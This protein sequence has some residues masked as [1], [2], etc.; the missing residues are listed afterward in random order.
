MDQF[1]Q[2]MAAYVTQLAR[3]FWLSTDAQAAYA[4]SLSLETSSG[5]R[6][7]M[8][9]RLISFLEARFE[10]LRLEVGAHEH[11]KD[12]AKC[13]WDEAGNLALSTFC[14][15]VESL[16]QP[17]SRVTYDTIRASLDAGMT[18]E[19][20]ARA[21]RAVAPPPQPAPAPPRGLRFLPRTTGTL[22]KFGL[23]MG[24]GFIEADGRSH[25]VNWTK[26][27]GINQDRPDARVYHRMEAPMLLSFKPVQL[28]SGDW[29]AWDVTKADGSEIEVLPPPF[30]QTAEDPA[31]QEQN[32]T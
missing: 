26:V 2:H 14:S 6:V 29:Q 24:F 31:M 23:N 28:R 22:V 27:R 16:A 3:E 21:S 8:A 10:G 1:K 30:P 9:G 20:R 7:I 4:A 19:D 13:Y 5:P 11:W 12:L 32:K 15:P 18:P 25:Y 17:P